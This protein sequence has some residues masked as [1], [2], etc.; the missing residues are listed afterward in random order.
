M[1]QCLACGAATKTRRQK[2]YRYTECGLPN[3]VID[4]A[5]KV[6][7]CQRCGETYTSIPAIP[8]ALQPANDSCEIE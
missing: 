8:R 2:Q 5:V 4:D 1:N 6:T 7:T 3:I